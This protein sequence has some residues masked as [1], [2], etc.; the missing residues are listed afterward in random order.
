MIQSGFEM[1]VKRHWLGRHWYLPGAAGNEINKVCV[2]SWNSGCRAA[3]SRHPVVCI[4][5]VCILIADLNL[6]C[7][8]AFAS[9]V[10][11][12]RPE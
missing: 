6:R 3:A 11:D 1:E 5:F 4:L 2:A 8:V 12:K 7:H 9:A 10:A